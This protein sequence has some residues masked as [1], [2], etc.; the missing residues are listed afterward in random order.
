[1][2]AGTVSASAAGD[3]GT[4]TRGDLEGATATRSQEVHMRTRSRPDTRDDQREQHEPQA[5]RQR[6]RSGQVRVPKIQYRFLKELEQTGPNGELRL[7]AL[8]MA[9]KIKRYPL[10]AQHVM[11][12]WERFT[13]K[14]IEDFKAN[15]GDGAER[16][17]QH[18]AYAVL[19]TSMRDA[20]PAQ[21]IGDLK[22]RIEA[23][24]AKQQPGANGAVRERAQA[25]TRQQDL[26][27]R[28]RSELDRRIDGAMSLVRGLPP[29][30][31]QEIEMHAANRLHDEGA[32]RTRAIA[33]QAIHSFQ[34]SPTARNT[35]DAFVAAIVARAPDH[36][37]LVAE[38]REM[39]G[40]QW[41]AIH[42]EARARLEKYAD[43]DDMLGRLRDDAGAA[44]VQDAVAASAQSRRE[45]QV[46]ACAREQMECTVDPQRVDLQR[47]ADEL[48]RAVA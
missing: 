15:R 10:E 36:T 43:G 32:A 25:P 18:L 42:K 8:E 35:Q 47:A 4:Q 1:V 26:L 21:N 39:K 12:S 31:R 38:V 22:Q 37:V 5:E 20:A 48:R 24:C 28:D 11:S 46:L 9:D 14:A 29:K 34:Q 41:D 3:C 30:L 17:K 44:R 7:S 23:V 2:R 45:A 40:E 16:D 27:E 13:A 33:D 6:E 19:F